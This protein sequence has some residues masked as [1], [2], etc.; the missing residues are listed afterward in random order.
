MFPPHFNTVLDSNILTVDSLRFKKLLEEQ[1]T[2]VLGSDPK[3]RIRQAVFLGKICEQNTSL[4][5]N[6]F[7]VFVDTGFPSVIM[8]Y[9]VR[10]TGKS[11]TLGNLVEGL[12]SDEGQ[13]SSGHGEHALVLFDTLGHFWQMANPP[14]V[15]ES[16]QHEILESWNLQPTGF[17]N[18]RVFVPRGYNRADPNWIEFSL[19]YSDMEV[20]DW[21]GVLG[22]NRYDEPLGQL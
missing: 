1:K 12:I 19:A 4:E 13:I 22:T 18:M 20:D 2:I 8:I 10:G 9:G 14:P 7:N 5:C 3:D 15:S 16:D 6:G 17:G 21:V 11:Y